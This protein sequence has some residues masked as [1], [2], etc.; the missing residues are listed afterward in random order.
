MNKLYKTLCTVLFS[1]V[2]AACANTNNLTKNSFYSYDNVM[3]NV[4]FRGNFTK[5]N[6]N[7]INKNLESTPDFIQKYLNELGVKSIFVPKKVLLTDIEE[8]KYLRHK[9]VNGTNSLWE[10]KFGGYINKLIVSRGVNVF[11][12]K[13]E[14]GH[15][16]DLEVGQYLN[17]APFSCTDKFKD[18]YK[19]HTKS[20]KLSSEGE[21]LRR[22]EV[23]ADWYSKF[24]VSDNSRGML[25][26]EVEDYYINLEKRIMKH[27][28]KSK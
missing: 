21:V 15:A 2:I 3:L 27:S 11:G 17:G 18:L 10:D 16:V 20:K 24:F 1:L 4:E 25:P 7:I 19:K 14:E 13:H 5:K 22:K 9:Y 6:K 28:L 8:L 12:S 23:F 26:F